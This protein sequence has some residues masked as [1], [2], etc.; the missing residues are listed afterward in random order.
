MKNGTV[1]VIPTVLR[2]RIFL[3]RRILWQYIDV[4]DT[5]ISESPYKKAFSHEEAIK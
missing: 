4:Y 3:Y 2:V 1:W 5:L